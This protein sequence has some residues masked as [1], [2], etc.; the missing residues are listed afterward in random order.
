MPNKVRVVYFS[1]IALVLSLGFASIG[2]VAQS[3]NARGNKVNVSA[4]EKSKA[5]AKLKNFEKPNVTKGQ[6]NASV[7]KEKINQ[8]SAELKQ[9]AQAEKVKGQQDREENEVQNQLNNPGNGIQKSVKEKD[10]MD[11]VRGLEEVAQEAENAEV[12]T[13]EAI[14]EVEDEGGFKKFLVGTSYKNLGQLRSSLAHNENQIRKLIRISESVTDE[15]TKA[16]IDEQLIALTQERERIKTVITNN[17]TGFSLL[18]WVFRLLNGYPK[19]SIDETEENNLNNDV[20]VVIGDDFVSDPIV[21]VD[22]EAID[23]I[24]DT[25]EP[26]DVT[27]PAQV[28]DPA[29]VV[30]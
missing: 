3:D 7:H 28:V 21:P 24:D 1:A 4:Q 10:R 13:V 9:V 5:S 23:P 26:V 30:E 25:V 22:D 12:E 29:P 18:G 11:I 15:A 17:E 14:E 8:V 16:I 27:D 20:E 19:D 2:A 6:T